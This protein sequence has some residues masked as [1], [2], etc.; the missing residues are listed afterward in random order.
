MIPLK[1]EVN[2]RAVAA[3]S[4]AR[5]SSETASTTQSDSELDASIWLL[6]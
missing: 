3:P 5:N 4:K 1:L 2:G 6:T